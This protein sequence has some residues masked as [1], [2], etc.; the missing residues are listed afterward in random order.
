M[1]AIGSAFRDC[2]AA[3]PAYMQRVSNARAERQQQIRVIAVEGDSRDN[4]REVLQREAAKRSIRLQL[5]TCSHGGPYFGSIESPAR[6]RAMS[7]VGNAIFDAVRE[8]D[9]VLFYVESD[10][11]WDPQVFCLLTD[12][13]GERSDGFDV[14]GPM[15]MAGPNFYDIWA[16]RGLDGR[17]FSPTPPYFPSAHDVFEVGSIGSCLAMR[18][19]VARACRIRDDNCLVGW[20]ADARA[21]GYRIAA[22]R[23][24]EVRHP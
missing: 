18:G 16:Y 11:L 17:R 20:C 23:R 14:F 22:D 6:F 5:E 7:K 13:A 9:D 10:L 4:T 15:V 24:V 2:A 19:E 3:I 8:T 1:I 21:K 12:Q